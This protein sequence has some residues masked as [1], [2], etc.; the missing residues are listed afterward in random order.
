VNAIVSHFF[1]A[2]LESVAQLFLFLTGKWL[3]LL[4]SGGRLTLMPPDT[5][6]SWFPPFKRLPH[7]QIGVDR[8]FAMLV[9]LLFW[10]LVLCLYV[11]FR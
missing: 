7:G 11:L 6:R 8:E 9:A 2:I 10:V 5:P 1:L 4:I 3:L